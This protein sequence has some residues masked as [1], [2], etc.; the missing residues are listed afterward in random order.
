MQLGAILFQGVLALVTS[1]NELSTGPGVND[2]EARFNAAFFGAVQTRHAGFAVYD[3]QVLKSSTLIAYLLFMFLAP[4]PLAA[5][6][7]SKAEMQAL[8]SQLEAMVEQEEEDSLR[9]SQH[10][11]SSSLYARSGRLL[12]IVL[13]TMQSPENSTSSNSILEWNATDIRRWLVERLKFSEVAIAAERANIDGAVMAKMDCAAWE[14]LGATKVQHALIVASWE[15]MLA[16][17]RIET[18]EELA[19]LRDVVLDSRLLLMTKFPNQKVP[20]RIRVS[21]RL[22]AIKY[23]FH[24]ISSAIIMPSMIRDVLF[25]FISAFLISIS[26]N[27]SLQVRIFWHD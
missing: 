21:T 14:E 20:F 26:E 6:Q 2:F 4:A 23:Q 25:L 5:V 10:I 19:R 9:A 18:K 22:K 7:N 24:L 15:E 17:D 16:K 13:A 11:R 12:N 8:E 3:M 27:V 1:Y